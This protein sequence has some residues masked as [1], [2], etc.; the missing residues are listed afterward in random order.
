MRVRRGEGRWDHFQKSVSISLGFSEWGGAFLPGLQLSF[1]QDVESLILPAS[2]PFHIPL[3]QLSYPLL[4]R[5][6]VFQD[7]L[8]SPNTKHI[9]PFQYCR[10]FKHLVMFSLFKYEHLC[11]EPPSGQNFKLE[12]VPVIHLFPFLP[13]SHLTKHTSYSSL[14]FFHLL[15]V[16]SA[17]VEQPPNAET[18]HLQYSIPYSLHR[19]ENILPKPRSHCFP[20]SGSWNSC[21]SFHIFYLAP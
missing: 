18:P 16:L 6:S 12:L 4:F 19:F 11:L 5:L 13:T 14:N 21:V 7:P 10:T 17:T 3:P 8:P 9:S 1:L 2:A 20:T 15:P